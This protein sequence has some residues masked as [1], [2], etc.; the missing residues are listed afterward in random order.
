MNRKTELRSCLRNAGLLLLLTADAEG[1]TE[2][3]RS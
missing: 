1:G 3:M 2:E